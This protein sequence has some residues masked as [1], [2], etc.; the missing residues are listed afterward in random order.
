[1]L[2]KVQCEYFARRLPLSLDIVLQAIPGLLES[3]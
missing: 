2:T 3:V 1:M